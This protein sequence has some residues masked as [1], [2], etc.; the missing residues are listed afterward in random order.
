MRPRSRPCSQ[1]PDWQCKCGRYAGAVA[2]RQRTLVS[3]RVSG[4]CP[5]RCLC[6]G[7]RIDAASISSSCLRSSSEEA[8]FPDSCRSDGSAPRARL[9]GIQGTG[10]PPLRAP[11]FEAPLRLQCQENAYPNEVVP[12]PL[13]ICTLRH[14]RRGRPAEI[15]KSSPNAGALRRALAVSDA[16]LQEST[17]NGPRQAVLQPSRRDCGCGIGDCG[18]HVLI[19]VALTSTSEYCSSASRAGRIGCTPA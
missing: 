6:Y 17:I 7:F 8:T 15:G 5:S 11:T 16:G 9:S 4:G 13:A 18:S 19:D 12:G 3:T 10:L 14:H 2:A 1:G